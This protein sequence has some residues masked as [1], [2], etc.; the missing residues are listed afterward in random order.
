M[1][2]IALVVY[3]ASN[4]IDFVLFSGF[5]AKTL[6]SIRRVTGALQWTKPEQ[7]SIPEVWNA[8]DEWAKRGTALVRAR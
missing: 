1:G 3:R 5:A 8:L 7:G 2:S 4:K 6:K